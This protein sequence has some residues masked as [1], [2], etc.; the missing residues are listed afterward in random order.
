M[1]L[2]SATWPTSTRKCFTT[3]GIMWNLLGVNS[4]MLVIG[5]GECDGG[6]V[7][8]RLFYSVIERGK[9]YVKSLN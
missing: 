5:F 6:G 9:L 2:V 7:R 3:S 8:M 4:D 1:A